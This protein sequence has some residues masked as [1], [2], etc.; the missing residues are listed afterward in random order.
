MSKF[1][2][3]FVAMAA[4]VM[5]FSGCR[6]EFEDGVSY[7]FYFNY[8]T[9]DAL[10]DEYVC[11]FNS[12]NSRKFSPFNSGAY[13]SK[14]CTRVDFLDGSEAFFGLSVFD[15]DVN[16]NPIDGDSYSFYSLESTQPGQ[17]GRARVAYDDG[18]LSF[19]KIVTLVAEIPYPRS[20]DL[21]L[22]VLW[23][24]CYYGARLPWTSG[25]Y[26]SW[27]ELETKPRYDID[28]Y[29]WYKSGSY[30]KYVVNG[31]GIVRLSPDDDVVSRATDGEYRLPTLAEFQ[32]LFDPNKIDIKFNVANDVKVLTLTSKVPG[33]V[34]C[35]IHL[36]LEGYYYNDQL[37]SKG[38]QACIW[39]SDL[40]TS[41]EGGTVA[42]FAASINDLE[43]CF[44]DLDRFYGLQVR[45]VRDKK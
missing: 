20:I 7:G 30:S 28:S 41:G 43:I 9:R 6:G 22:S 25:F 5:A 29:K 24:D 23:S 18:S 8:D 44:K 11:S 1:L 16:G 33:H 35:F 21:G 14:G 3:V 38:A 17:K 4:C 42:A 37:K 27:G 45:P 39:T 31:D 40:V 2:K 19:E 13:L 12:S 34:G 36:S 10:L 26:Y 32:E 15:I